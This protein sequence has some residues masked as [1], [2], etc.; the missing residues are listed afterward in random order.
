MAAGPI[1]WII[2]TGDRPVIAFMSAAECN[3]QLCLDQL[4]VAAILRSQHRR[5]A[6]PLLQMFASFC[7][8]GASGKAGL[9]AGVKAQKIVG[10]KVGAAAVPLMVS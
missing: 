3:W 5:L 4:Q 7:A 2:C 6:A 9:P 1:V 10:T 8:D